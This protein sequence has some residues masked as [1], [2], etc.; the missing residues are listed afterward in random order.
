[1]ST[2]CSIFLVEV[3]S[4][5]NYACHS[6][7]LSL[8][9]S[10]LFTLYLC[11]LGGRGKDCTPI[12]DPSHPWHGTKE[13]RREVTTYSVGG[14]GPSSKISIADHLVLAKCHCRKSIVQAVFHTGGGG[15]GG[16]AVFHTGGCAVF[17]I[18]GVCSVSYR[19]GVQ[20]FIQGGGVCSVSYRGGVCSVSYRGVSYRGCV[21]CFIQ[22]GVCSVSY[23]GGVQCFIQGGG[24]AL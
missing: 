15:G 6:L 13:L 11:W 3:V 16:C 8:S 17:H 18:G 5:T 21:Q 1:M 12:E 9:L 19:E 24:G 7:S 2:C 10:L 22:G 14:N 20:C 23:R 4:P